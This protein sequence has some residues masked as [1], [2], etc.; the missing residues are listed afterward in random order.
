MHELFLSISIR[1][2]RN[3]SR[4]LIGKADTVKQIDSPLNRISD[5]KTLINPIGNTFGIRVDMI[6]KIL[7]KS[8]KLS[9]VQ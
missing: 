4:F 7:A 1:F 8:G 2:T 6:L 9:A 3:F 5:T